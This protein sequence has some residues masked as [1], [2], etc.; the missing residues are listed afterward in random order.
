M[1]RL[2]VL[3]L[4]LV[5]LVAASASAADHTVSPRAVLTVSAP[6]VVGGQTLKPGN[7]IFE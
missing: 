5:V 4:S 3:L 2:V 6:M 7:Y 1:K